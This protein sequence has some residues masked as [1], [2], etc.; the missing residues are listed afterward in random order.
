MTENEII[1]F[2]VAVALKFLGFNELYHCL[3]HLIF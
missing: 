1:P 2:E 3:C